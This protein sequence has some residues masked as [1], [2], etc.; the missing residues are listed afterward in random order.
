M[1]LSIL[2]GIFFIS[3]CSLVLRNF[4][5]RNG[6][7]FLIILFN[8]ISFILSGLF[9]LC[10]NQEI[11]ETSELISWSYSASAITI[12]WGF[13]IDRLSFMFMLTILFISTIIMI[14]SISYM[15]TDIR[16]SQF[17]SFLGYFMFFMLLLVLS[18]NFISMFIG[19]E[20]VGLVSFLLVNFWYNRIE[21]NKGAL[22]ALIFN[23]VGDVGFILFIC[24]MITKYGNVTLPFFNIITNIDNLIILFIFLAAAGKSAQ[25]LL[26]AWLPD[27]MEGPTPVSALLHSATMVTAGIFSLLRMSSYIHNGNSI[28]ILLLLIIGLTTSISAG[29]FAVFKY[30]IKKVIAFS[31]C[32]QLG[33]LVC[34]ISF[35]LITATFYH[36]FI[37]AFFKALLFLSSGVIIHSLFDE[38][39]IRKY[40]NVS[41]FLTLFIILNCIG[42]L[43]IIGFPYLSGFYSKEALI[44]YPFLQN[45][46]IL[47]ACV[48]IS[49]IITIIYSIRLIYKCVGTEIATPR[50]LINNMHSSDKY[51]TS[52]VSIL[53]FVSI[54]LGYG[55]S[56]TIVG[57]SNTIFLNSNIFYY[58]N[59]NIEFIVYSLFY[60]ILLTTIVILFL[61]IIITYNTLEISIFQSKLFISLYHYCIQEFFIP[62]LIWGIVRIYNFVAYTFILKCVEKGILE[63]MGLVQFYNIIKQYHT[64]A[65]YYQITTIFYYIYLLF[66]YTTITFVFLF[67][68]QISTELLHFILVLL[69]LHFLEKKIN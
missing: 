2:I 29:L 59:I 27:A 55:F 58:A 24:L 1:I 5:G 4:I 18:N 12:Y 60:L 69:I 14:Y 25:L 54:I 51:I 65:F 31:T 67:Y 13:F 10:Y 52:V 7:C 32:S 6:S 50:M 16:F 38:Q 22:K 47:Q 8:C 43:N 30:D 66:L 11:F 64:K 35:G 36:L 9:L 41:S 21:S 26:Y 37:H 62:I 42:T 3:S 20:G 63:F 48:L 46:Y 57:F 61:Y 34:G 44:L 23:R 49:S 45:S 40:G 15:F 33:L 28:M 19:W 68:I 39:D 17:I 53:A 56:D